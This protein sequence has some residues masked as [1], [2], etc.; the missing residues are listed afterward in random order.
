MNGD[1]QIMQSKLMLQGGP[2]LGKAMSSDRLGSSQVKREDLN[3]S[4]LEPARH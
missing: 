1:Y 4:A 2:G 3:T